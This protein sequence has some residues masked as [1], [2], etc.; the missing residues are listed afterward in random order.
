MAYDE[1]LLITIEK[2]KDLTSLPPLIPDV[3]HDYY[4]NLKTKKNGNDP[5]LSDDE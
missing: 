3:F 4:K 2:K 1:E 5:V